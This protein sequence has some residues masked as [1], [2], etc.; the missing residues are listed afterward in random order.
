[1]T[2]ALNGRYTYRSFRHD[3]V[4]VADGAVVGSPELATPWSPP[5]V[6]DVATD[7]AGAVRGTL[8]FGEVLALDVSGRVAPATDGQP[9]SVELTG[10]AGPSV[11]RIKGF[12]IPDSNH[13]IGTIMS[14]AADPLGQPN[15]TL[16]PFVLA[17]MTA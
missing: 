6:L 8:R 13:V 1:M 9:A 16:G 3:P 10:T 4:V 12:F 11:N 2:P 5:G 17:P 14:V 7:A 15:G